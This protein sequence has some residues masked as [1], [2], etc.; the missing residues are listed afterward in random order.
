ML[1]YLAC[2]LHGSQALLSLLSSLLHISKNADYLGYK[3]ITVLALKGHLF[4]DGGIVSKK[5][6]EEGRQARGATRTSSDPK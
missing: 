3:P 1:S 5:K 6:N 2:C 4:R